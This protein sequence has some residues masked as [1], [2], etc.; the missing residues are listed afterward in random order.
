MLIAMENIP[1][2]DTWRKLNVMTHG[3]LS[4]SQC[5]GIH[6]RHDMLTIVHNMMGGELSMKKSL[7]ILVP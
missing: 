4:T 7:T 2:H 6:P 1:W 5:M 3:D